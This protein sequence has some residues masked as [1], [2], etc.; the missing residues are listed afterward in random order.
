M[1]SEAAEVMIEKR[2]LAR[3]YSCDLAYLSWSK[4]SPKSP[5]NSGL[6]DPR[7]RRVAR[8][9]RFHSSRR[10][11]MRTSAMVLNSGA[12]ALRKITEMD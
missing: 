6:S 3:M 1:V 7:F 4:T 12:T 5:G 11:T 9:S 8:K 2:E 10:A